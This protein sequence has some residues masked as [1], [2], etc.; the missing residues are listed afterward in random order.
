MTMERYL[1]R[2]EAEFIARFLGDTLKPRRLLDICCGSGRVTRSLQDAGLQAVGLDIKLVAL[3]LFR[4]LSNR[5]PLVQGDAL[6]L[7]IAEGGFDCVVAIHCFDHLDRFRFLQECHRVLCSNGL[8]LFDSLNRNSYKWVLKRL[9]R[10]L[11]TQAPGNRDNRWIDILSCDEVLRATTNCG[12]EVRAIWGYSW[13]PFT[14]R[15]NGVLVDLAAQ[16]EQV[17]QLDRQYRISPRILIAARKKPG[18]DAQQVPA[19]VE[20]GWDQL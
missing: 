9:R 1:W 3:T 12:F 2:H 4:R 17:L 5:V 10:S 13:V 15:S 20:R 7:P 16:M 18:T 11:S 14:R 6:R 8:L 19:G